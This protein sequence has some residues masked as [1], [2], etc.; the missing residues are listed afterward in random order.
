[1]YEMCTFTC[2]CVHI[3]LCM[4]TR[5]LGCV[6]PFPGFSEHVFA[7]LYV[8]YVA[9]MRIVNSRLDSRLQMF[10]QCQRVALKEVTFF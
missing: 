4:H 3:Q 7:V 2:M 10:S 5:T 6:S 1:M 9:K 8:R